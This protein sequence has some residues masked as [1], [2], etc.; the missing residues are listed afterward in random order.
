MGQSHGIDQRPEGQ[1]GVGVG[2]ATDSQGAISGRD[3]P[4]WPLSPVFL[5]E[6]VG[7]GALY[8][9]LTR[10]LHQGLL[11]CVKNTFCAKR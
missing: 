1:R 8:P 4:P 2:V 11:S 9:H 3:R 5:C 10:S 7:E 6:D